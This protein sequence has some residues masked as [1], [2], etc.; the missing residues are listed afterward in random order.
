[1]NYMTENADQMMQFVKI[2]LLPH[3]HLSTDEKTSC[4][5]K[6][7]ERTDIEPIGSILESR[8]RTIALVSL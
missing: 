2:Y 7:D 5:S 3:S 6:L 4:S 1:M 8:M